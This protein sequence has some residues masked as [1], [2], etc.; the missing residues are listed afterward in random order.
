[1]AEAS[2]LAK[3]YKKG[4]VKRR[5]GDATPRSLH[6]ACYCDKR[7]SANMGSSQ[8]HRSIYRTLLRYHT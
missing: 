4:L 7:G 6:C 8:R 3:H 1:M 2:R 5:A